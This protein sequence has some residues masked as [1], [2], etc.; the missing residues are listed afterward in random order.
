MVDILHSIEKLSVLVF[1][2]SSMFQSGLGLTW[3]LLVVPLRRVRLVTLALALNFLVA[4]ALAWLVTVVIPLERGHAIALLLLGWAAGAP[5]LPKLIETA[6]GNLNLAA[7]ITA[8][9]TCGTIVFMPLGLP[10]LI[11]GL[12]AD[13]WSIA[14]P[15]ILLIL[16]PLA[17]GLLIRTRAESFA[18]WLVPSLAKVSNLSLLLLFVLL[19]ALNIPALLGVLGSGAILA[20]FIYVVCLF[21]VGW[22]FAL[23]DPEARGVLALA[24]AARNFGSAL[25]PAANSFDDPSITVALIVNAIIGLVFSFLAARWVRGRNHAVSLSSQ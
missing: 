12:E 6:R 20:G 16:L 23:L 3:Q 18:A 1:L 2:I 14:R 17:I 22:F 19:V 24:T 13:P 8:L 4:P 11:P 9:L 5:F 7:A 21:V 25:V 15:L 10:L